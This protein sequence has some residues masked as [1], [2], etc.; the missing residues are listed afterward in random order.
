MAGQ[1]DSLRFDFGDNWADYIAKHYS[2]ERVAISRRHLLGFLKLDTLDGK[3]F[4]DIGC[5]SGLHSL[6]AWQAGAEQV[7]SFDY[8]PMSV[9]TTKRL[10][11]VCGNPQ[12]W[13]VKQGSILDDQFAAALPKSDIVYSWGVLHHTGSMWRALAN[14]AGCMAEGGLFY[15]ALYSKD[16]YVDPD[17]EYWLRIKRAYNTAGIIRRAWMEGHYIARELLHLCLVQRK[18][19]FSYVSEYKKSRGMSYLHDVR[20]WLGGYPMEF[21]GN[22]E[23]EAFAARE[24]GLELLHVRAGA[25]N[26]EYLFRRRGAANYWDQVSANAPLFD[27]RG[28]YQHVGGN[29]W[30]VAIAEYPATADGS[31]FMLYEDGSPVG[32]LGAPLDSILRWGK[33]RYRI[34]DRALIFSAT[35]NSDP[36][37]SGKRYQYRPNFA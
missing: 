27:L 8:D 9:A 24:L 18:N 16:V 4:L 19:P 17:S 26:T 29:A 12:N 2:E 15:V 37:S 32:W 35:D 22:K 14:A 6:A 31:G 10:R 33:G 13:Q 11:E 28:P 1:D 21:A 5:G 36:N 3:S 34:D 30:R 25:G 20:D 23:T 7:L